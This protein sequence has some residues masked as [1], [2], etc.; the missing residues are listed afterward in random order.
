M[1]IQPLSDLHGRL[2]EIPDCDLLLLA[3]DI[4]P[5]SDA[6]AQ[7]GWLDTEFRGWLEQLRQRN[8]II[9]GIAG[10]HDF[11]FEQLPLEV[12]DLRLP[13]TY[14]Q[15]SGCEIVR[16]PGR[17]VPLSMPVT[18]WGTPWVPNLKN[19]AFCTTER[20]LSARADLI[21]DDTDIIISHTPPW[22]G[23]SGYEKG[24]DFTDPQHGSVHAGDININHAIKRVEPRFVI[25]GHIHEGRGRYG[26]GKTAV[27]NASYLDGWYK[28]E[29][30]PD[31]IVY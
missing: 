29:L 6:D 28:G 18:I 10:N 22:G 4:C 14:L 2:P 8:I 5:G 25:C 7:L 31:Q 17:A 1:I 24:W 3:G 11:V 16:L 23:G 19:W 15:D 12:E 21:P 27:I 13:W 20:Q 30:I 9:V 26:T